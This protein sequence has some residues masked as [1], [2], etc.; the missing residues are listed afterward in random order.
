M[1]KIILFYSYTGSSKAFAQKLAK[2]TGTDIEEVQ[3]EK[4]PGTVSAY[5]LG[6]FAAL[7]NIPPQM[8]QF[9]RCG[10]TP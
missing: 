7:M 9:D 2:E 10:A 8:R 3:T 1:K 4:R 6:S 5:V